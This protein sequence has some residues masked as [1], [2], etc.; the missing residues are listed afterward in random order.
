M[1]ALLLALLVAS[2]VLSGCLE[3]FG[4][5]DSVPSFTLE[6][7]LLGSGNSSWSPII[8]HTIVMPTIHK[9]PTESGPLGGGG[10]IMGFVRP[11]VNFTLEVRVV[12][13]A[14]LSRFEA[15]W[16]L[17][18]NPLTIFDPPQKRPASATMS[19]PIT[20][21]G[22]YQ[23]NVELGR[24]FRVDTRRE[25]LE[26]YVNVQWSANGTIHPFKKAELPPPPNYDEMADQF[27]F[28]LNTT[29]PDASILMQSW[30]RGSYKAQFNGTDVDLELV[31]PKKEHACV[32]TAGSSS[33][34]PTPEQS[35]ET[36]RAPIGMGYDWLGT[37]TA[38]VGAVTTKCGQ[39]AYYDNLNPVPY[40]LRLTLAYYPH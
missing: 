39:S 40:S 15:E 34:S 28:G 23:A 36:L 29:S 9:P 1:R 12:D 16:R 27:R 31:S 22:A 6:A 17:F 5:G 8:N 24:G 25:S 26:V 19:F 37:W 38:R 18:N 2:P 21:E 7:R 30:Y 11:K 4:I 10:T 32:G 14:N 3:G 35:N 13:G 33:T 20:S